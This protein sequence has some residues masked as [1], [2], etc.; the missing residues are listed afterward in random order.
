LEL[1]VDYLLVS[2]LLLTR[3]RVSI[4]YGPAGRGLR[5]FFLYVYGIATLLLL[6]QYF[7]EV[8]DHDGAFLFG[9]SK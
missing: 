2:P 3:G 8:E 7:I 9:L 1:N 4:C 5:C 6:G